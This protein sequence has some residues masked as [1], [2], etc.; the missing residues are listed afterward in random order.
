MT[1]ERTNKREAFAAARRRFPRFEL[2]IR[3]L[4]ESD[5]NFR[6]ICADLAAAEYALSAVEREPA[7]SRE[8]RRAEWQEI[9]DRLVDEIA[10]AIYSDAYTRGKRTAS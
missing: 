5:E 6:D 1:H 9:V 3:R 2:P 7:A 8:T 10:L 4:L